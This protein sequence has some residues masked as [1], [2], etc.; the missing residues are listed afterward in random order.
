MNE[1][2]QSHLTMAFNGFLAKVYSWMFLG[3][4]LTGITSY[5]VFAS[6]LFIYLFIY[7]MLIWVFIIGEIAL[8]ATLSARV[9][10]LSP[11]TT[12]LLFVGYS[13]LNGVTLSLIFIAY[14]QSTL[15]MA[16]LVTSLTFGVMSLYGY[17]TK[18]DLTSIGSFLIFAVFGIVIASVANYFFQSSQLDYI[19]TIIGLLVFWGLT[20]Y[21][22]QKLKS[23]FAYSY[24]S[25][26]DKM[27]N[28][29]VRGA[30][31]LYLDFIN[32]FIFLL[33]LFGRKR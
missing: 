14:S 3:L 25:Q 26:P 33:R 7:P 18:T 29:A 19:I 6:G 9:N 21:D 28:Y 27:S 32:I 1:N 30:L 2:T 17:V 13:I 4:I 8:V 24:Q 31:T 5:A 15:T 22:T 23:Y 10:K 16:F 11:T 20:A 12:R